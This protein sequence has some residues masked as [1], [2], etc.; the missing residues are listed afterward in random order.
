MLVNFL[1]ITALAVNFLRPL[2][3]VGSLKLIRATARVV[4]L[5]QNTF[6]LPVPELARQAQVESLFVPAVGTQ[7]R[8]RYIFFT[9]KR[10]FERHNVVVFRAILTAQNLFSYVVLDIF[11]IIRHLLRH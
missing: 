5:F 8:D 10:E 9:I 1:V 11:N 2:R 7:V 3:G 4:V 6:A